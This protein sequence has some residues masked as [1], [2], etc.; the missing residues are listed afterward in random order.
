MTEVTSDLGLDLDA[1]KAAHGGH[2][3]FAPSGSAIWLNTPGCLI[4]NILAPDSA[5]FEAAYGTVGHECGEQWLRAIPEICWGMGPLAENQINEAEPRHRI[6]ETVLIEERYD[7]FEVE[8]DQE[9]LDYVRQYVEWVMPLPGHHYIETR[10]DFSD[11]TPIPDQGGTADHCACQPGVLTIS[12]LKMGY[13]RVLAKHNTQLLLYAYG[14]FR[15]YDHLYNF[16]RIIVRIAQPRLNHFDAWEC[17]REDLLAFAEFV[18]VQARAAW[19]LGGPRKPGW[20]CKKAFCNVQATCPAYVCWM[21]EQ[22]DADG[23]LFDDATGDSDYLGC[24]ICEG[25]GCDV[26]AGAQI[27]A[28]GSI[29]GTYTVKDMVTTA[30]A[31]VSGKV[32]LTPRRKPLELSTEALARLLPMRPVIERW[33]GEIERELESRALDGEDVP[34]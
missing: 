2:S 28:D 32:D 22:A 8:I 1:I 14:F 6:G 20:W 5:G 29:E 25:L 12:D 4:P 7:T 9:M 31:L 16:E 34:G 15:L 11:L 17:S 18:R 21:A 23:D 3:I 10:V 33:F 26:C 27:N 19:Q 30:E 24:D 13:I